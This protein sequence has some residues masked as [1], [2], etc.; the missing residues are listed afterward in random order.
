MYFLLYKVKIDDKT[1]TSTELTTKID[2]SL[3]QEYISCCVLFTLSLDMILNFFHKLSLSS[4]FTYSAT[5]KPRLYWHENISF[6]TH[7]TRT[8]CHRLNNSTPNFTN[9]SIVLSGYHNNTL[10]YSHY[11]IM[12]PICIKALFH[13]PFLNLQRIRGLGLT[14]HQGLVSKSMQHSKVDKF[15]KRE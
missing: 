10:F 14:L 8:Y 4:Y 12:L 9:T 5:V 3:C 11:N 15:R 6:I 13:P 7:S 1:N 2:Y